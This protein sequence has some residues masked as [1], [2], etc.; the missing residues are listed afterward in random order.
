MGLLGATIINKLAWA[1]ACEVVTYGLHIL[2]EEALQ[3]VHIPL[4]NNWSLKPNDYCVAFVNQ[5]YRQS[6]N[7]AIILGILYLF[8]PHINEFVHI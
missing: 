6:Y 3:P 2:S 1:T 4:K 8:M 7:S 5:K